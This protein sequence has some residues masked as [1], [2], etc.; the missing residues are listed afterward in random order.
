LDKPSYDGLSIVEL[1]TFTLYRQIVK[2]ICRQIDKPYIP[3]SPY[4]AYDG[5]SN[6]LQ[7]TVY[8]RH[9]NIPIIDIQ[10]ISS[11]IWANKRFDGLKGLEEKG[12]KGLMVFYLTKMHPVYTSY[13]Y[14]TI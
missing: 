6:P 13:R 4:H 5:L 11:G 1:R 10:T 8:R 7:T 9:T 12:L 14:Q 2:A 3:I